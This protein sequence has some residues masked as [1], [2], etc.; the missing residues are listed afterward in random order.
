MN[1]L[2]FTKLAMLVVA[3]A[4]G[5][6][7]KAYLARSPR[8]VQRR[9]R[10][11]IPDQLRGLAWQLISG[12]RD[13]LLQNEGASPTIN[14]L[15]LL[16]G[17]HVVAPDSLCRDVPSRCHHSLVLIHILFTCLGGHIVEASIFSGGDSSICAQV[18][19]RPW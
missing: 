1:D 18:S 4:G 12:G 5:A 9:V 15:P 10:K 14:M 13:L 19:S 8:K 2:G 3:G 11:G 17:V 6:D 16:H 7:W